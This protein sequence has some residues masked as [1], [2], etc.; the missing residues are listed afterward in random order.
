MKF[1]L[2]WWWVWF[3]LVVLNMGEREREPVSSLLRARATSAIL[4]SWEAKVSKAYSH[5]RS[6]NSF[7]INSSIH[8]V[9]VVNYAGS[10]GRRGVGEK[11]KIT[12]LSPAGAR[13]YALKAA[14]TVPCENPGLTVGL[15]PTCACMATLAGCH[16]AA[17]PNKASSDGEQISKWWRTV[18]QTME[19]SPWP[20][21]VEVKSPF[22]TKQICALLMNK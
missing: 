9:V 3:S 17:E 21:C 1:I 6:G 4:P 2:C 5:V 8:S 13:S 16:H 12:T 15:R 20:T 10:I 22:L 14:S 11:L 7:G 19:N 18:Y